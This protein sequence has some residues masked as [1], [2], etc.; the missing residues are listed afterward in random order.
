MKMIRNNLIML[1]NMNKFKHRMS[2]AL[3][4]LIC[5]GC[6]EASTFSRNFPEPVPTQKELDYIK[7]LEISGYSNIKLDIPRIGLLGRGLQ[8]YAM[9]LHAPFPI[10]IKNQDS[11]ILVADSMA[12]ELYE[13]IIEDSIIYDFKGI[14]IRFSV[15]KSEISDDFDIKRHYYSKDF[16]EKWNGFKVAETSDGEF[17]RIKIW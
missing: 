7:K 13:S 3:Y 16:L 17:Q 11:I 6:N 12:Y 15:D 4:A 8:I 14:A 5:T 10:T 2:V 9:D 1:V